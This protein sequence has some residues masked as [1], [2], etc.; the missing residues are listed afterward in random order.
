MVTRWVNMPMA[1]VAPTRASRV[2]IS[3]RLAASSDPNT[4][5]STTAAASTPKPTPLSDGDAALSATCPS[6]AT[7]SCGEE[8]DRAVL[9]RAEPAESG[10][11]RSDLE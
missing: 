8:C 7:C 3:G 1:L 4:T 6:T 5:I 10:M 11:S 2:E 9:T